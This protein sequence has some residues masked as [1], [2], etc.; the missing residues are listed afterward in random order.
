MPNFDTIIT[1]FL[2]SKGVE[3]FW[4][5]SAMGRI[6]QGLATN[7]YFTVDVQAQSVTV[8]NGY[9]SLY[10]ATIRVAFPDAMKRQTMRLSYSFNPKR[11]PAHSLTVQPVYYDH[12]P[13]SNSVT[14]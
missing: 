2:R 4:V 5:D 13:A 11:D 10:T 1:G 9:A 6:R 12:P 7:A 8:V 3:P 14:Q